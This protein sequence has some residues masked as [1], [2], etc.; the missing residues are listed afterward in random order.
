[1]SKLASPIQISPLDL[2]ATS[3]VAT[4]DLGATAFTADGRRFRYALAG[5]TALVAGKLQQSSVETTSDQNL[6]AVAASVGDVQIASTST[7]TVAANYYA[8]GWALIT[9]TPGLGQM[10]QISGHAAFTAAAP[11]FNL[12]A[13]DS[14][15]VALTTGSRIDLVA[16]PFSS[17]IVNPATATGLPV[18]AA[19]TNNPIATYGW[20]QAGGVCNLLADGAITV[21]TALVAS[22]GVAGAVEPLAGVQASVGLAV[23]G[24][25]T[26]EYGAVYLTLA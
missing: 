5:A 25:S 14:I 20:I 17:V 24:I 11:T 10:Y 23:T 22:N 26:T 13:T 16:N 6:T 21:G 19:V 3:T 12:F 18:G 2:F 15:R 7:I 8:Q 9:V 4:A 1:M